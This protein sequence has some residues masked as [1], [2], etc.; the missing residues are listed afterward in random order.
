M[1]TLFAMTNI[2]VILMILALDHPFT[3]DIKVS[4]DAFE[5]IYKYLLE[6]MPK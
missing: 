6:E 4:S 1:T 2:I 5:Q 3:G